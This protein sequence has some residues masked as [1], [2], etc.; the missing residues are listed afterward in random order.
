MNIKTFNMSDAQIENFNS[1]INNQYNLIIIVSFIILLLVVVTLMYYKKKHVKL[2][3]KLIPVLLAIG[4]F[5]SLL[6]VAAL[7]SKH[8]ENIDRSTMKYITY[9]TSGTINNIIEQKDK[10]L[11]ENW[12]K[13]EQTKGQQLRF[14][15]DNKNY[16]VTIDENANVQSGDK[17]KVKSDGKLVVNDEKIG[18]NL[19]V[20]PFEQENTPIVEV[21]HDGQ[22]KEYKA[23]LIEEN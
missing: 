17:I 15:A 8:N 14:Y 7:F 4:V 1:Y 16:Y 10:N 5:F 12:E 22:W 6:L 21:Q 19:S 2:P 18:T 20:L 23:I 11:D 9:N 13:K 3:K